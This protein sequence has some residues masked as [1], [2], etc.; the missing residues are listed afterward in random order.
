[1]TAT[2]PFT[3]VEPSDGF[4]PSPLVFDSPHSWRHWPVDVP[5]NA[6]AD[7]LLTSWDAYMDELW[8]HAAEGRAPVVSACFHRAFVDANRARDDIDLE[9]I[10][11]TWPEVAKPTRKSELG[12]GLIRRYALPGVPMYASRLPAREVIGRIERFYDPY[13]AEVARRV[14][15]ARDAFGFVCHIDC[16]SMKSV[17]NA[18]NDDSGRARPDVV[19][20]D[21][22]G[23]TAAPELTSFVAEALAKLG[24]SVQV[25]DPYKG[26]ELVKRHGQPGRG[27]H[28]L[29]IE[30]NRAAYMDEKTCVKHSGYTALAGDMRSFVTQLLAAL[31]GD[32]GNQLRPQT[33][34]AR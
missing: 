14:A 17:G 4:G 3:V 1:M 15:R 11:G 28:S 8:A 23:V 25:N 5:I 10:D 31:D 12:L 29:Q 27:Q 18:M 13:H 2:L 32:L 9:L 21:R 33:A 24:L 26:A 22:D 20:S 19:V 7:A 6:P 16:H 30:I 34:S